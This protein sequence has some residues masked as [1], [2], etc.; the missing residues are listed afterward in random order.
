MEHVEQGSDV[1][2]TPGTSW[3][4]QDKDTKCPTGVVLNTAC[5]VPAGTQ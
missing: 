4:R 5:L 1:N 3:Y 2:S